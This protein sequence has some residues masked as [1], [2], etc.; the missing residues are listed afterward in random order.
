MKTGGSSIAGNIAVYA[1]LPFFRMM[2][3]PTVESMSFSV[4]NGVLIQYPSEAGAEFQD[5]GW[6]G[7]ASIKD[8]RR[9]LKLF[10]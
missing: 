4:M 2:S 1:R 6:I 9:E 7:P 8:V 10:V 5:D 3:I